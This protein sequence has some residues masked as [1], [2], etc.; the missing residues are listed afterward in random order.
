MDVETINKLYDKHQQNF[1][2]EIQENEFIR[3][4]HAQTDTAHK[5]II[6][7]FMDF[8][9]SATYLKKIS[10][11]KAESFNELQSEIKSIIKKQFINQTSNQISGTL[12][13]YKIDLIYYMYDNYLTEKL[14]LKDNT[15]V[16]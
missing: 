1:Q 14:F 13:Q 15:P 12:E 10:L 4:K 7:Y 5:N 11:D 16:Q 9:K 8:E 6:N 3:D 2:T